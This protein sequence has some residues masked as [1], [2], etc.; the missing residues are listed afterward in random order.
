M[1]ISVYQGDADAM[2]SML[3]QADALL[4]EAKRA[5]RDRVMCT[6]AGQR[7]RDGHWDMNQVQSAITEKRVV[8]A[9]QPIVDL[10]TGGVVADEALARIITRDGA[11]VPAEKFITAA[12]SM[13]LVSRV[14]ECVSQLALAQPMPDRRQARSINLSSQFLSDLEQVE[15]LVAQAGQS[16][17]RRPY[18]VVEISERK[19][20]EIAMMKRNLRPLVDAGFRIAVDD[21]GSGAA[22]FMYLAELPVHFLKIEGWMVKRIVADRKVRQLIGAIAST[23]RSLKVNTVAECVENAETAQVLCDLGVDWAQGYFFARPVVEAN[24]IE[25][26]S[27]A[28]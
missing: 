7:R 27:E 23:A 15:A 10:R 2:Q 20:S 19:S 6:G 3:D 25:I 26:S 9:Y 17:R 16:G 8:A 22:S 28:A 14:D 12:E 24:S 21:F 18:F 1:G 11:L 13:N 4:Y 5:G